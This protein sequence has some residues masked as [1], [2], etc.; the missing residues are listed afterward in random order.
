VHQGERD[1]SFA[2]GSRAKSFVT[3][4]VL[5]QWIDTSEVSLPMRLGTDEEIELDSLGDGL[6]LLSNRYG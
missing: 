4:G 2:Q 3:F 5:G 1:A 6:G